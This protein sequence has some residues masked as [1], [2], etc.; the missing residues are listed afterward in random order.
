MSTRNTPM[1][2]EETQRIRITALEAQLSTERTA[3]EAAERERDAYKTGD[4]ATWA[5]VANKRLE[6]LKVMT[7]DRD[8]LR[9]RLEEMHKA[10]EAMRRIARAPDHC[11][12]RSQWNAWYEVQ[13]QV[14]LALAESPAPSSNPT[15]GQNIKQH[16][17]GYNSP[18][19]PEV[20]TV[21]PQID[22]RSQTGVQTMSVD[23][24]PASVPATETPTPESDA[25]AHMIIMYDE[26]PVMERKKCGSWI[27][28]GTG[29]SLERRLTTA[30][31]QLA[32]AKRDTERL[33]WIL[34][35]DSD[36]WIVRVTGDLRE[37]SNC[38]SID[39]AMS[40]QKGESP[41]IDQPATSQ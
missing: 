9:A 16:D 36:Y 28:L 1:T 41:G 24:A 37:L 5:D 29:R 13:R 6:A 38:E 17:D 30:L 25:D 15:D 14:E 21:V 18:K 39:A 11:A 33:D 23:S 34:H 40:A 3:R 22:E 26:C 10:L 32:E 7:A 31:A 12:H 19:L 2:L 20:R 4:W 27:Y 8:A 35:R